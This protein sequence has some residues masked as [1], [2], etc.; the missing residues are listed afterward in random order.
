MTDPMKIL[1]LREEGTDPGISLNLIIFSHIQFNNNLFRSSQT[2]FHKI[3]K[4][5]IVTEKG[6][7]RS[8]AYYAYPLYIIN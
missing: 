3:N 4:K 1:G 2:N 7:G 5:Y 8:L 6:V